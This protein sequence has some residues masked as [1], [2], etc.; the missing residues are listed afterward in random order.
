[1]GLCRGILGWG[2][3]ILNSGRSFFFFASRLQV[4][5]APHC[6]SGSEEV[7]FSYSPLE[8]IAPNKAEALPLLAFKGSENTTQGS[9]GGSG[10]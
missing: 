10:Y 5:P 9:L 3:L 1:M 2:V 7:T 6:S 8:G 4:A